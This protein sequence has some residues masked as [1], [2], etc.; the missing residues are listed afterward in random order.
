[1]HTPKSEETLDK[2]VH[3]LLFDLD[4]TL[5]DREAA[6]VRFASHFYEERLRNATTMT[7]DEVVAKM[8]LWDQDGYADRVAM[9]AQWVNEW[10]EAGL[11]PE[12]LLPYYRSE[13]KRHVEPDADNNRLL[14]DLNRREVPW[15]H[16]H[17]RKHDGAN[18]SPV[19][20]QVSINSPRS[21]SFQ[22]RLAIRNPI[23]G[24]SATRSN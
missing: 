10:P 19:G 7:R 9:F 20:Q 18:T 3:G 17:Q 2:T 13:M 5:I 21:S 4:N 14:A 16:R 1:M 15:G 6:F 24:F 22:K 12:Q 23:Q 8:V 11:D